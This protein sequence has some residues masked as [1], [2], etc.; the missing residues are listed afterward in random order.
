VN[1]IEYG[2]RI[3]KLAVETTDRSKKQREESQRVGTTIVESWWNIGV[4]P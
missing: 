3:G 1:A 2:D 4:I